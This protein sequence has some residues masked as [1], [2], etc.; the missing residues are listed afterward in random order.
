[1]PMP[2]AMAG[3]GLNMCSQQCAANGLIAQFAYLFRVVCD[4][5]LHKSPSKWL[6]QLCQNE[7]SFRAC[8]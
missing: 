7:K 1:M 4:F 2:I 6:I 5:V 8:D 3:H